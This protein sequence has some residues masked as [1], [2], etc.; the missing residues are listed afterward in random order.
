MKTKLQKEKDKTKP[1]TIYHCK[2]N[3]KLNTKR[4]SKEQKQRKLKKNYFKL[5]IINVNV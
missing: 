2:G 5:Q 1:Y 4:E 3:W